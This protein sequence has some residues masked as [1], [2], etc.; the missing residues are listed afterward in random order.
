MGHTSKDLLHLEHKNPST[1]P[2]GLRLSLSLCLSLCMYV[3][4]NSS[5]HSVCVCILCRVHTSCL[6]KRLSPSIPETPSRWKAHH[7]PSSQK[8]RYHL[9]H[10]IQT[11]GF[12][13][14]E[15][16]RHNLSYL[17]DDCG[18][19]LALMLILGSLL[20][21]GGIHDKLSDVSL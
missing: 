7:C 10:Q 17:T 8:P 15:H 4:S 9:F 13:L 16:I 18:Y 6:Q 1:S 11:Y 5:A 21:C 3:V 20:L 14:N 2:L 19:T 12:C